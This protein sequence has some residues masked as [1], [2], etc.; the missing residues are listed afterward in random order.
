MNRICGAEEGKS[1]VEAVDGLQMPSEVT[2]N[3]NL[4]GLGFME[5]E[6]DDDEEEDHRD[7][8]TSIS[9]VNTVLIYWVTRHLVPI[10]NSR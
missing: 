8:G 1:S 3:R 10:S 6:E 5:D 7:K 9:D 2:S 4:S